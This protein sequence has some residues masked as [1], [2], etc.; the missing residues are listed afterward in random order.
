MTFGQRLKDLR[1]QKKITQQ[2]LGDVIHVSKVSISGYE[3]NN[4]F[5]D[6]NTL[7]EIADYFGVTVD[8][9][10][11]RDVPNWA[12]QEDIIDLEEMLNSNVN[13]AY[14]GENLTEEEKQRVKDVLTGIFWEKIKDRKK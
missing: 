4:R 6:T 14:G 9:L 13:M 12:T 11:G 1:T 10:L 2:E 3:N 5:P 8:Y 7:G